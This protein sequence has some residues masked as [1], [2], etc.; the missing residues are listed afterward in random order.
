MSFINDLKEGEAFEL[1]VMTYL[2]RFYNLG[3][4]KNTEKKSVDLM[5]PL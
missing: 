1:R 5:S 4:A 3:L 2:N